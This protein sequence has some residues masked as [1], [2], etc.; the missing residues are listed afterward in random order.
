M[1]KP[2]LALGAAVL[3]VAL[4]LSP[5]AAVAVG[6]NSLVLN[7]TCAPPTK[8]FTMLNTGGP[9]EY[10]WNPQGNYST[11][12]WGIWPGAVKTTVTTGFQNINST[13][14]VKAGYVYAQG[15]GTY[16]R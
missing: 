2:H 10:Y 7:R 5:T 9:T 3:A 15:T 16:C 4:G 12:Y 14:Y 11:I 13:V 1:R 6:D 8:V